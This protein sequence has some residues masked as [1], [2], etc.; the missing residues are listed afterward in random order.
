MILDNIGWR[1]MVA[2][3]QRHVERIVS[4]VWHANT[5]DLAHSTGTQGIMSLHVHQHGNGRD[6]TKGSDD[7]GMEGEEAV[8][9]GSVCKQTRSKLKQF[10][11]ERKNERGCVPGLFWAGDERRTESV[12][13]FEVFV[14]RWHVF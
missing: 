4:R 14:R 6:V 13:F 9:E 11:H 12:V 7:I 3:G 1:G 8:R 10:S 2:A 5:F